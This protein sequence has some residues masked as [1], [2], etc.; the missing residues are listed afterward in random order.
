MR[1]NA[2]VF[3]PDLFGSGPGWAIGVRLVP[4]ANAVLPRLL[5]HRT[6]HASRRDPY[7][8]PGK[9]E[10]P[11]PVKGW[12]LLWPAVSAVAWPV[13]RTRPGSPRP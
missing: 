1:V 8:R 11:T 10:R 13:R 4:V 5:A 12:W 7:S 3:A 6:R 9:G 2:G